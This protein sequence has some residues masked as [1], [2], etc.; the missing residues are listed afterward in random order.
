M[1]RRY[2]RNQKRKA[3]EEI[4]RLKL[5]YWMNEGL[6]KHI[7]TKLEE[8]RG[9]ISEMVS[10][11]E[12]VCENSIALPPKKVM[13]SVP[14]DNYRIW[15]PEMNFSAVPGPDCIPSSGSFRTIDLYA[16]RL[17]L[18]DNRETLQAAVHL[19]YSAGPHSAYMISGKALRTIP[20]ETLL[21]R[22]VPEIG[23]AL[24]EHMREKW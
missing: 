2:G 7:G 1:S 6:L 3:R 4:A 21:R 24:V 10:V 19:E 16:L 22:L 15:Q 14:M 18:T 12:S 17:F 8:A 13:G 11:I 5:A 9:T 23:R 20:R